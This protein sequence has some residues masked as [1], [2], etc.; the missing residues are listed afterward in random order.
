MPKRL[1]LMHLNE[2]ERFFQEHG[3]RVTIKKGQIFARKEEVHPWVYYLE[4]GIVQVAFSY[5]KGD[6]RLIGYFVPDMMFAQSK[7]FYEG[8]SGVLEYE[9]VTNMQALRVP[10]N[11]YM[12]EVESNH[13]FCAEYRECILHNQTYM[14]DRVI[15]QA[16]P[17]VEKKFL[18]W[19]L[20]MLKYYGVERDDHQMIGLKL[21]QNTIADFLFVSRETVNKTL[22]HF[23]Q[24]GIVAVEKKHIILLDEDALH[25]QL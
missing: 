21:T 3:E 18:R 1:K 22:I 2:H 9:A 23:V 25:A 16:E 4:A 6:N 5:G 14:I 19:V 8:D 20:F 7:I 13:E 12:Q 11:D 17:N 15:Y 10:R 24:L